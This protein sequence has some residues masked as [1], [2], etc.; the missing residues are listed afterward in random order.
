M[1]SKKM[2]GGEEALFIVILNLDWL[3]VHL[4]FL[5]MLLF[6]YTYLIFLAAPKGLSIPSPS[7]MRTE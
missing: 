6:I 2:G 3:P 5:C 4:Q 1:M 7:L